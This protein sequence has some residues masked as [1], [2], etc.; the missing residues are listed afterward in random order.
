MDLYLYICLPDGSRKMIKKFLSLSKETQ[1]LI[2]YSTG[3]ILSIALTIAAYALVMHQ[4]FTMWVTILVISGLALIQL[5]IQLIFF[6]HLADESRPR[7]KFWTF[8]STIS[9][10]IIIV[11]GSIWIMFDLDSR[12]MMS[13]E[14]MIKYMNRQSGL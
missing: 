14:D 3:F 2:S 11:G 12:M 1:A 7:W 13:T 9:I 10:L 5:V 4:A 8:L 6:L